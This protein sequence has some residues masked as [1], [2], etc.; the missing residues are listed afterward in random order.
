MQLFMGLFFAFF[1]GAPV[2]HLLWLDS[3][4]RVR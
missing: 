3:K 1:F 4:G 2:V